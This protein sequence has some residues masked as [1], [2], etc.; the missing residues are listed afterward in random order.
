M[1]ARRGNHDA[2]RLEQSRFG[3]EVGPLRRRDPAPFVSAAPY[4]ASHPRALAVYCSDGRFTQAIEDLLRHLGHDRLDT[5]TLP[6]GPGLLNLWAGSLLEADQMERAARFLIRG[7][8]IEHV[9]L[10]AHAGCG[11]Y[12]QRFPGRAASETRL[13]Q[14]EDLQVAAGS[15]RSARPGITVELFYASVEGSRVRFDPVSATR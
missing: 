1:L 15:L 12:R 11:Y 9:V 6:G 3:G 5:L 10:L 7:H 13:S 8:A 4:E 14:L 2:N